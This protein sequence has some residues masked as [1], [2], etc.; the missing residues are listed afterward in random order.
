MSISDRRL[1]VGVL[2]HGCD[3]LTNQ[4]AAWEASYSRRHLLGGFL[5]YKTL[6]SETTLFYMNMPFRVVAECKQQRVTGNGRL[7]QCYAEE[8]NGLIAGGS[9]AC[10]QWVE[11]L[12]CRVG[13]RQLYCVASL[14]GL[15]KKFRRHPSWNRRYFDPPPSQMKTH[16]GSVVCSRIVS[17]P[18]PPD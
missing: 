5:F 15:A 13:E 1:F 2:Y 18:D 8:H 14:S 17:C 9:N 16:S 12:K 11:R 6:F 7:V 10:V 4:I 3:I